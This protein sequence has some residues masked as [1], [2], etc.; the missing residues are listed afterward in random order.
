MSIE[1]EFKTTTKF[2]LAWQPVR[3]APIEVSA[4]SYGLFKQAT[5]G[6]SPARTPQDEGAK[7]MYDAWSANKGMS[8]E[9]AM[10]GYVKFIAEQKKALGGA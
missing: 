10:K 1:E 4:K 3:K 8:K 2:V 9:D 7:I 5:V 6:D